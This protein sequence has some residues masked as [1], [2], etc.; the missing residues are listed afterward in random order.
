[1]VMGWID[2]HVHLDALEYASDVSEVRAQARALGVSHC[3]IPSVDKNN[4]ESVRRLA[5]LFGDFYALGIHPMYTPHSKDEDLVLL[6]RL[7]EQARG[8]QADERLLAVGEIGLDGFIENLDFSKQQHF[9]TEQLK[10][11][12]RHDL[13]LILHVR[14][15][16]D[17]L[18]K[19]LRRLGSKGGIAHAFNGS[20]QQAR[21][22]IDLGFCL[23]FGG[24]VTFE[25]ANHLRSL[26]KALPKSAIVLET[27]GPDI[28]PHWLYVT[29][30]ERANGQPQ[31]RND[32]SQVPQ[33]ASVV[34]DLMDVGLDELRAITSENVSRVLRMPPFI[35]SQS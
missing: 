7:I 23:G 3:V 31:N 19:E 8:P 35:E 34:S 1:M 10:I 2:S 32:P 5:H 11:A 33:I 24:A 14:K 17:A 9:Y 4:F 21:A 6:E 22:F 15:S 20:L 29:A 13:P 28:P 18:L 16:A 27:D 30:Q 26:L 25:R 12:K